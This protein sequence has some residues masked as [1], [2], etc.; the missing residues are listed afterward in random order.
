[1]H[2]CCLKPRGSR[3][4]FIAALESQGRRRKRKAG[5]RIEKLSSAT[6]KAAPRN[7]AHVPLA[8]ARHGHTQLQGHRHSAFP[9]GQLKFIT[10]R[11]NEK[12]EN[13]WFFKNVQDDVN[14]GFPSV[15]F[16]ELLCV[17]NLSR[18]KSLYFRVISLVNDVYEPPVL[19]KWRWHFFTFFSY[20][21]TFSKC[22]TISLSIYGRISLHRVP[23]G[24]M[25][26][27]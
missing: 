4:F 18:L 6:L 19:F 1:M 3:C 21:Q 2:L 17:R 9:W 5:V 10:M 15:S 22:C 14:D 8:I 7:S 26:K 16:F 25:F 13:K 24:R 11:E 20:R 23:R 27:R 12:W